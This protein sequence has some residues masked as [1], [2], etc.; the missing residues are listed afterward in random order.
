ME[1]RLRPPFFSPAF[2]SPDFLRGFRRAVA[3]MDAV[4]STN[5]L[6]RITLPPT[7]L[8]V[9]VL[10]LAYALPGLFGH[11]PWKTDD[12]IGVGIMYRML[13][14][15]EWL[16]PHLAGEIYLDDG[17]FF[18]WIAAILS[19]LGSVV[20]TIDD[21]ARL[22][23]AACVVATL[24]LLRGAARELYGRAQADG[25]MMV[26][27]GCLGLMVHA[28]ETLGELGMLL[29]QALA[30]HGIALSPRKPHKGGIA[31]G[32]GLAAAWLSK[33]PVSAIAALTTALLVAALSPHWRNRR[34]AMAL[35]EAAVAC[36]VPVGVWIALVAAKAPADA[37]LWHERQWQVLSWPSLAK[38][39]YD[40]K[41]LSW[42]AWPAWPIALWVLWE[43]RRMLAEP[44]LMLATIATLTS[45]AVLFLGTEARDVSALA[46]LLPL[47]LLAGAGIERLRR[48]A[49]HALV[50]FGGV[51]FTFFAGLV[52]LGWFAMMTGVPA[53]YARS[54]TRLEPGFEP[55]FQWLPFVV[56]LALTAAWIIVMFRS[57]AK[58]P[59]R[60]VLY[61]ACGSTLI[62]GLSM[63]LWL[64]WIDYGK[65]YRR[66]AVSMGAALA[67]AF[68]KGVSCIESRNLGES[69][70]AVLDYHADIVTLRSELHGQGRCP[71]L[72]VQ[73]QPGDDDRP[74]AREWK[75]IWE[76]N[77]P[78]D[79][80]RFRL[81]IRTR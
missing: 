33:G 2:Y 31:L 62:W 11:D 48:G 52:W 25:S 69:Q 44:G 37:A 1:R 67:R 42:S 78:R 66:V 57:E 24:L 70:R 19:R 26:L 9:C 64:G 76:G 27:L 59:Y 7:T 47:A 3:K 77:R 4:T 29:G 63:T 55:A 13:A 5:A 35:V 53:R 41:T 71:A 15:G 73:G 38:F 14:H 72:L 79:R 6:P 21:G 18:Y 40:L 43:R 56:A 60:S 49:V 58:S 20:L 17:P 8:F 30:L 54:F 74:L 46:V 39:G 80:E 12:A 75:R 28:H 65:S 16:V 32:L 61:W 51:S 23:S 50:W 34:Y 45:L 68:P 36:A 22:A 81:Y 10:A